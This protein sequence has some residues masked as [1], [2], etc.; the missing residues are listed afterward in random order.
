M[1]VYIIE[2]TTA[3]NFKLINDGICLQCKQ[4]VEKKKSIS[5]TH[6]L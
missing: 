3:G 2:E 6:I 1:C 5:R 4:S